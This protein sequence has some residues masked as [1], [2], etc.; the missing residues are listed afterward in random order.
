MPQEIILLAELSNAFE[1]R[2][3]YGDFDTTITLNDDLAR[4]MIAVLTK[5][6]PAE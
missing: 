6:D 5:K 4:R 3:W 1:V 2:A